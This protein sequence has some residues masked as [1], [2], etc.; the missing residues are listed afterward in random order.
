[1]KHL[2]ISIKLSEITST[3]SLLILIK[4]TTNK[5]LENVRKALSEKKF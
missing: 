1:M 3:S 2:I 5:S 4:I